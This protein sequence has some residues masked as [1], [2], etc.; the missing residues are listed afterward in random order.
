MLRSARPK[1]ILFLCVPNSAC[2][3]MAGGIA[4][5]MAPAGMRIS[6]AGT[7]PT[8][9]GPEA[10]RV[11]AEI[12]IDISSQRSNGIESPAD[13]DTVEAVITLGAEETRGD[14]L[15]VV[16]YQPVAPIGFERALYQGGRSGDG[17]QDPVRPRDA[18]IR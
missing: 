8:V 1:H 14:A 12:G 7:A 13:A 2:S 4:R 15:A 9:V 17:P 3:Q 5:A 10:D 18:V 6:S 16:P 11:L